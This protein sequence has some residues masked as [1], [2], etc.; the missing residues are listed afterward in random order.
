MFSGVEMVHQR[1]I[2][3]A[4]ANGKLGA[5]IV[6]GVQAT[7][8]ILR[9]VVGTIFIG[10]VVGHISIQLAAQSVCYTG[11]V[12]GHDNSQ[13]VQAECDVERAGSAT[14][15][16]IA[17]LNLHAGGAGEYGHG[18][19]QILERLGSSGDIDWGVEHAVDGHYELINL[20]RPATPLDGQSGQHITTACLDLN[21]GGPR[22][23]VHESAS[24]FWR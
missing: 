22:S 8:D 10:K 2:D 5:P 18:V 21:R 12:R 16:D 17:S 23:C 15:H 4:A 7:A 3:G 6:H 13:V 14:E 20:S 9:V 19:V 1:L 24:D 11:E